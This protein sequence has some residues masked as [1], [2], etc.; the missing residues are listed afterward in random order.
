MHRRVRA[1]WPAFGRRRLRRPS[2]PVLVALRVVLADLLVL[3]V[4]I[5]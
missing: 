5:C 2:Q 4:L 1:F 3:P